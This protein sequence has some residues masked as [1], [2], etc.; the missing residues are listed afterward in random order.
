VSKRK[1]RYRILHFCYTF[2]YFLKKSEKSEKSVEKKSFEIRINFFIS[3]NTENVLIW[4]FENV[5]QI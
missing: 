5:L 4:K 3:S 2:K 1:R